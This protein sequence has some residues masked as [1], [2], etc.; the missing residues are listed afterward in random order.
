M[1]VL[2]ARC[3]KISNVDSKGCNVRAPPTERNKRDFVYRK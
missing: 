3:V 1:S 2:L